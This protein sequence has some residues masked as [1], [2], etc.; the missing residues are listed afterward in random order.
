MRPPTKLEPNEKH[1]SEAQMLRM[2]DELEADIRAG[3]VR[4]LS[5]IVITD[6]GSILHNQSYSTDPESVDWL[7]LSGAHDI[8]KRFL[9][10]DID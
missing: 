5:Y 6:S 3:R 8:A 2:V 9:V 7:A 4:A 1:G 10:S